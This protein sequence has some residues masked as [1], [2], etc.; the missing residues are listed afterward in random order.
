MQIIVG[1]D[2]A[3]KLSESYTVLELEEV[4]KDG[5]TLEAFV[6]IPADVMKPMDMASIDADV[7]VHNQYLKALKEG[8]IEVC[9]ALS[10]YLIG[11]FGGEVD[12]FYQYTLDRLTKS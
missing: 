2:V 7:E 10:Q 9:S 6:V 12:T 1:R 5:I 4:T 3:D 8:N 11:R